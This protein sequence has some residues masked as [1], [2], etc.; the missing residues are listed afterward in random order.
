MR[1]GRR[2]RWSSLCLFCAVLLG[3]VGSA[4]F[5]CG[6]GGQAADSGPAAGK[7]L[8]IYTQ[9]IVTQGA[10][11]TKATVGDIEQW[12]NALWV[13]DQVA[14]DDRLTGRWETTFSLDRRADLSADMWGTFTLTN[15]DG[16]WKGE[17][18]GT[19]SKGGT[20]HYMLTDVIGN[21]WI[22]PTE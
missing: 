21:G 18:T 5:A 2:F 4:A 8:V 6:C 7:T 19:I 1:R 17:W 20:V 3:L 9:R 12:R 13:F 22:A 15:N 10:Y 11:E 14:S 16:S